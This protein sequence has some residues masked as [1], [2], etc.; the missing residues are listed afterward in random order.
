[1]MKKLSIHLNIITFLLFT[2]VL[3]LPTSSGKT[4]LTKNLLANLPQKIS[5]KRM[6]MPQL[7]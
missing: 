3:I 2:V 6:Q 1:M 7:H 4:F 5:G